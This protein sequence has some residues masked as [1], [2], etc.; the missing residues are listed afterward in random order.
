MID[1]HCHILP[2]IDDGAADLATSME[3]ARQAVADGITHIVATPHFRPPYEPEAQSAAREAALA[4]LRGAL[5]AA[6][7]PLTLL[8]GGE[9]HVVERIF[10]DVLPRWPGMLVPGTGA[11]GQSPA[12]LVEMSQEMPIGQAGDLLFLAQTHNFRMLLAHPE[13]QP[14]FTGS[15]ETLAPLVERGLMLQFNADSFEGGL[16]SMWRR[17]T[18]LRL[19]R[20]APEQV[21]LASDA[22][23]V[24]ERP[25]RLSPARPAIT[26]ALGQAFWTRLTEDNP[27]ALLGLGA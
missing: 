13:R 20:L 5:A 3:L 8:A 2:G 17:R 21:F 12:V 4:T 22:H 24:S 26:R 25:C 11:D 10:A 15:Y 16:F 6:G 9:C 7:V 27:R 18:M 1:I 19:M 14:G 23:D